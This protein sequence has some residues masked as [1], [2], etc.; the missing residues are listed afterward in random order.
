MSYL[1]TGA[2]Q[3]GSAL[4]RRLVGEGEEVVVLRRRDSPVEGA[5]VVVG[6]AGDRRLLERAARG[7]TA[8]LHCIHAP[9]DARAW[10]RELPSREAAAMDVA[11]AAGI[12]VVFPESVYAFGHQAQDLDE[13]APP[14]PCSPLGRVRADLLAARAA[15]PA[16]TRS[17]VASDLV[18]RGA[19]RT[20]SVP[21]LT[22]V[23]PVLTGRAPWV[24]GD[25]HAPHSV[26][27]LED[28]A[29]AML[30]AARDADPSPDRVLHAPTPPASSLQELADEVARI[31][32]VPRRRS[33]CV[34][35]LALR[36]IGAVSPTARALAQQ[37]YLWRR[38]CVLQ[39]GALTAAGMAPRSW[40]EIVA[41]SIAQVR[42]VR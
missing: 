24:M 32:G 19:S 37:S 6:D 2:G 39:P 17:V 40:E 38:P 42:A 1:I 7:V 35:V 28:M 18:G 16:R 14:A 12:P 13:G 25:P 26:T 3:I 4:A 21:L 5:R 30:A 22:V 33:H 11:A 8:I 10:R 27:D 29:C 34:P 15:H 36:A 23:E 20:A 9:Y 41:G 31:A